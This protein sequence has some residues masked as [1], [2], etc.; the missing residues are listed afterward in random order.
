MSI[1]GPPPPPS[2]SSVWTRPAG[3]SWPTCAPL[4]PQPGQPARHDPEYVREGVVSVF[5][6]TEPPRGRRQVRGSDQRTRLDFA[7]GSK[8]LIDVHDPD[9]AQIVLVMDQLA[10]SKRT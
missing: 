6:V 10:Q 3:R 1:S 4:P 8:D 2:R 5:L 7:Q 9:A